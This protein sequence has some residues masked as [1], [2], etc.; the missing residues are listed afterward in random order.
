MSM[1]ISLFKV[2]IPIND[3]SEF[4]ELFELRRSTAYCAYK[5]TITMHIK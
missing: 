2:A 4:W 5:S 1:Y 3:N